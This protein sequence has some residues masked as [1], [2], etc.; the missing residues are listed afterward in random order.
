[1]SQLGETFG[2]ADGG[3]L[4]SLEKMQPRPVPFFAMP[5]QH[6]TTWGELQLAVPA[7]GAVD[8]PM[9]ME[10]TLRMVA[11]SILMIVVVMV[12]RRLEVVA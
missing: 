10:I 12:M 5:L 6:A 1:M 2:K 9:A 4:D 11:K 3:V 8:A 7:V